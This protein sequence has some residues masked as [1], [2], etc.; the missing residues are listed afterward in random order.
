MTQQTAPIQSLLPAID[1]EADSL[2]LLAD[3]LFNVT[4]LR[5]TCINNAHDYVASLDTD[6]GNIKREELAK[7]R[8]E[9]HH[10]SPLRMIT[11]KETDHSRL[12]G[13]LLDPNGTH[14]QKRLF[15]T[16]FL[17]M[18]GVYEPL[19][20]EWKVTVEAGRIDILIRRDNPP[21]VIIIENKANDA[22]DQDG[23]LY[24]YWF[25]EI[26]QPY[27]DLNYE[28]P[29]T[30]QRF[31]IVYAPSLSFKQ[32]TENSLLRPANL[33]GAPEKHDKLPIPI[34][35]RFFKLDIAPWLEQMAA[36]VES[37]R[38]KVFLKLY[39]EIWRI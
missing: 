28:D 29:G 10:F 36:K 8:L 21:S 39:A 33:L 37:A 20:G 6:W 24:R 25:Q 35:Y 3:I 34:D 7:N 38:L 32:P 27:S 30:K 12:L 22:V 9:N 2:E 15:L 31:K 16:S 11:I 19:Q 13:E 17:D 18:L 26:Y 1:C 14:G 4:K 23:Q 5:N